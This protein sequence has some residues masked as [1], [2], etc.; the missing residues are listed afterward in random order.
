M[1]YYKKQCRVCQEI[2]KVFA[3]PF[4][5]AD[6]IKGN[7]GFVCKGF[8]RQAAMFSGDFSFTFAARQVVV[9]NFITLLDI[10]FVKRSVKPDKLI[11]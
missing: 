8:L 1:D 10:C 11:V 7:T 5:C 3:F 2:F 9:Q 6:G 4:V